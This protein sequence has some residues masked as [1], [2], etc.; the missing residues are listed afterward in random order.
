M[1]AFTMAAPGVLA[2]GTSGR[3]SAVS[4]VITG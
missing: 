1:A 3:L 4:R 2:L